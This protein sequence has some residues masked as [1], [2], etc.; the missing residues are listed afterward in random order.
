MTGWGI[1]I[2]WAEN[3]DGRKYG[4]GV[5]MM[6]TSIGRLADDVCSVK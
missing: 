1:T 3:G 6:L 2:N 5:K 4:Y